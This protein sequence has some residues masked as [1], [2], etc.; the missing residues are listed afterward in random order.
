MNAVFWCRS[1]HCSPVSFPTQLRDKTKLCRSQNGTSRAPSPTHLCLQFV[2]RKIASLF[3][4]VT[5]YKDIEK[6][7]QRFFL[8]HRFIIFFTVMC[9]FT[10][11]HRLVGL[12]LLRL[13]LKLRQGFALYPQGTLSL[14]PA[15]PLTPG[16]S[17]RFSARYARC[18]GHNSGQLCSFLTPHSSFLIHHSSLTPPLPL[19]FPLQ[20]PRTLQAPH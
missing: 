4:G 19:P 7:V 2:R 6:A 8:R 10:F 15:S 5:L 16:L 18:W 1:E 17:L 9:F 14:D 20:A 13:C 12:R 11:L 3:A